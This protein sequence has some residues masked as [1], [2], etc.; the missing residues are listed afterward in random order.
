M[1]E[2]LESM[3]G[4]AVDGIWLGTFHAIAARIL[5]RHAERIGLKSNFTILDTDDQI[6]L[7]KQIIAAANIDDRRLPPRMSMTR[8]RSPA[9]P[10]VSR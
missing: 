2:R 10:T 4:A 9:A 8:S 1:R 7:V 3:V 6:R 5:R